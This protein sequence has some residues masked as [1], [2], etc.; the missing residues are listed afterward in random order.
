V[1]RGTR[2]LRRASWGVAD[3]VLSS[4]TN[5]ALSVLVA[6]S[7]GRDDFGAFSLVYTTY[8]VAL[9]VAR[10]LSAEPLVIRYSGLDSRSWRR[11]ATGAASTAAAVGIVL[12]L[13]AGAVGAISGGFAGAAFMMLAWVLPGL[14]IQDS[15]RLAFFAAGRGSAA[16]L[17]DAVWAAVMFP[18]VIF[19]VSTNHASVPLMILAWGGAATLA[20]LVGFVQA[21]VRPTVAGV[22]RWY[23]DH[24]DLTRFLLPDRLVS[25]GADQLSPYVIGAIGGLAA[26][27]GIRSGQLLLGPFSI[28]RQGIQLIAA[29]EGVRALSRS[30]AKLAWGCRVFSA[31][32]VG[33]LLACA[34]VVYLLPTPW[35]VALLGRNWLPGRELL[36]PLL[37]WMAG[38]AVMSGAGLGLYV[39]GAVDRSF[40]IG[41]LVSAV[42]LTGAGVGAA[43]GGAA[44]AAL[45][46]ALSMWVGAVVSWR[47]FAGA[48]RDFVSGT[49]TVSRNR[50]G[51]P[52][53]PPTPPRVDG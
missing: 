47:Q 26:V 36:L 51:T 17:N 3:Q 29:P 24:Q 42:G 7:V 41:V 38:A 11:A 6:R 33:V 13:V 9:N 32:S 53:S 25:L 45:G 21:R 27:G 1:I 8:L 16:F 37:A 20:A 4:A 40:R 18:T 2:I 39:L 50:S 48:R 23:R 34:A 15:W 14:L 19:L 44:A 12:G 10:P 52:P 31:V 35:G 22:T 46:V 49:A 28:V 5:F 43:V 30:T